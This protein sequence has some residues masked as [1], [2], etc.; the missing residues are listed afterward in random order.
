MM[1]NILIEVCLKTSDRN[2]I[3]FYILVVYGHEPLFRKAEDVDP[4]HF[5]VDRWKP[6]SLTPPEV[7]FSI[8]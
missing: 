3:R 4:Q 8:P 5:P 2:R 1:A 7:P 6:E